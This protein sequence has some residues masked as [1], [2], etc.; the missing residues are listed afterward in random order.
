MQDSQVAVL[1]EDINDKLEG[2]ADSMTVMNER[3]TR[4]EQN[5]S[6][7]ETITN[8]IKPM[9]QVIAEHNTQLDTQD[10]RLNALE[11]PQR[12]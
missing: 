5:V 11:M 10:E 9:Q 12:A 7:I 8:S 3:L 1:L 2:L 4:V 6:R